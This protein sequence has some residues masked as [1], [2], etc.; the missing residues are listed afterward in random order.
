MRKLIVVTDNQS[1]L[2]QNQLT[3][4]FRTAGIGWSHYFSN[5]WL[6]VDQAGR[7]ARWWFEQIDP[8]IGADRKFAV[9]EVEPRS[10]WARGPST[11]ANWMRTMWLSRFAAE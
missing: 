9:F 6:L 10:W 3:E 1:P 7:S 2:T 8:I 5:A 11:L 4:F